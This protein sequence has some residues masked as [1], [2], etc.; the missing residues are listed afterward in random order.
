M[1]AVFINTNYY[2]WNFKSRHCKENLRFSWW[3]RFVLS[4]LFVAWLEIKRS[5][6]SWMYWN[7]QYHT[8]FCLLPILKLGHC[9]CLV[10]YVNGWRHKG[11]MKQLR[12][13]PSTFWSCMLSQLYRVTVH[14]CRLQTSTRLW[15]LSVPFFHITKNILSFS[16]TP[17]CQTVTKWF[18][19]YIYWLC[20]LHWL[21]C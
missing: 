18:H 20:C 7:V 5:A 15:F 19:Y 2:N 12:D 4:F 9:S 13:M 17:L 3:W 8:P 1:H 21:I 16:C 11:F 14:Q 6:S 10:I